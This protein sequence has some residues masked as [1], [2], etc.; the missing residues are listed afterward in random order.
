MGTELYWSPN[1]RREGKH[2]SRGAGCH[3]AVTPALP[4]LTLLWIGKG[5]SVFLKTTHQWRVSSLV[6]TMPLTTG[7]LCTWV[8]PEGTHI[9]FLLPKYQCSSVTQIVSHDQRAPC[10]CRQGTLLSG[11]VK[12]AVFTDEVNWSPGSS[13]CLCSDSF[14]LFSGQISNFTFCVGFLGS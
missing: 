6:R 1:G 8:N 11:A 14:S 12:V 3:G 2:V 7:H 10:R 9:L 13:C 5:P 4:V